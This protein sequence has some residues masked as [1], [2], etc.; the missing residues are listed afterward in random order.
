MDFLRVKNPV[1]PVFLPYYG[2]AT[3]LH[4]KVEEE[5]EKFLERVLK[6]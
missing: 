6:R 3:R 1:C 2:F 5:M 4:V